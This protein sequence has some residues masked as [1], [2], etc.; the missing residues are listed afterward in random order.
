MI[1]YHCVIVWNLKKSFGGQLQGLQTKSWYRQ[2][3]HINL[4]TCSQLDKY[5]D[6]QK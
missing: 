2:K 4:A 5:S 3:V 6:V 1:S